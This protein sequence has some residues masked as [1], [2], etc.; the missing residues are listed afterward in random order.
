ML[1][2]TINLSW[3]EAMD[4]FYWA[5]AN[6]EQKIKDSADFIKKYNSSNNR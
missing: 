4:S 5:F 2:L 1:L 6:D 3:I